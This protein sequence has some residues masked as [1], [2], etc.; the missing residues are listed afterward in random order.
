MGVIEEYE[1]IRY[2]KNEFIL[3]LRIVDFSVNRDVY[4]PVEKS[5]I[6]FKISMRTPLKKFLPDFHR[7]GDIILLKN[8]RS[9]FWLNEIE[10]GLILKEGYNDGWE[11]FR[12]NVVPQVWAF[13]K[14]FIDERRIPI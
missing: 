12:S 1:A 11:L 6:S 8:C 7:L 2:A 13:D 10:L 4:H 5:Q 14:F 3:N 9:S